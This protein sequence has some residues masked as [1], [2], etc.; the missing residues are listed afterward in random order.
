[1]ALQVFVVH[2]SGIY[3]ALKFLQGFY[4]VYM[5][6]QGFARFVY[7]F[8]WSFRF[9]WMYSVTYRNKHGV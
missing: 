3:R 6:L 5:F 4:G 7:E 2:F 1:M 9:L 8:Y